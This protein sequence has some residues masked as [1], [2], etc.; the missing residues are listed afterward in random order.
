MEAS[1]AFSIESSS[2]KQ[3]SNMG[4][5]GALSSSLSVLP[6]PLQEKYSKLPDS[7]LAPPTHSSHLNSSGAVGHMFSS[8]P[9]FSTDL[10][11]SSLSPHE[12]HS[13]NAHFISQSS[14]NMAPL[15]L[16]YS[17]NCGPLHSP[18]SSLYSKENSSSW[19]MDSLPGFLDF[20]VNTS[21]ENGQVESNAC[22]IMASDEYCKRNDW[23]EWADQLI[24]D[25]ENLTSN[26]NDLI[27]DPGIQ[28]LEPKVKFLITQ[29]NVNLERGMISNFLNNEP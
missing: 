12:K 7:Q 8:Y 14:S 27:G 11:H 1:P 28:D 20:P 24:S 2:A 26:W 19:Q 18:T 21:I 4:M 3:L 13:R 25:D 15:P 22:N 16:S 17:S 5:S 10:H 6:T 29:I 23:S 9:G